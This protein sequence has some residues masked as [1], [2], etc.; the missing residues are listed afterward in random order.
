MT[1]MRRCVKKYSIFKTMP[2]LLVVFLQYAALPPQACLCNLK[3]PPQYSLY[4]V[5]TNIVDSTKHPS[6]Q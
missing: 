6:M 4:A 3:M 5:M 2:L 1:K